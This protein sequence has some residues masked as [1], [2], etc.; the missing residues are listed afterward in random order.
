MKTK[1]EIFAWLVCHSSYFV[2]IRTKED[3]GNLI[4]ESQHDGISLY[5]AL[6]YVPP[7]HAKLQDF[8]DFVGEDYSFKKH[9]KPIADAKLIS[10]I[11]NGIVHD[12]N[13]NE[14][15]VRFWLGPK[16]PNDDLP[17]VLV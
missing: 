10:C 15:F 7:F 14:S 3:I 5:V 8:V 6:N 2:N 4:E 17:F 1:E 13:T 16:N 9:I 12:Y 11:S